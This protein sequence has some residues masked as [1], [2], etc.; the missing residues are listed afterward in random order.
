MRALLASAP[1]LIACGTYDGNRAA[2]VPHATPRMGDGQPP[3]ARGQLTLGASSVANLGEPRAGDPD[4][5]V[6]IA[7]T[8][9]FGSLRGRLGDSLSLGVIYE[10]GL[11]RGAEP[12]KS[13][14]PPVDGGSIHGYGLSADLSIRTGDPRIR[15]GLGAD[16]VL[17][18]VPYVEYVTCPPGEP[19]FPYSVGDRGRDA[20]ETFA[21]SLTPS[22]R[23]TDVITVF[24]G[25][26][27]RQ[28]PVIRQKGIE[29][30]PELSNPQVQSGPGNAILSG[31]MAL[32]LAGGALLASAIVYWDISSQPARY[33]PGLAMALSIPIGKHR[34]GPP[35]PQSQS[36]PGDVPPPP[37]PASLGPPSLEPEVP[38]EPAPPR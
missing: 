24:A 19:C 28:H 38:S 37:P 10:H 2:L 13:P 32:S 25:L 34:R 31:G 35:P 20:V 33:G 15:I 17:W 23:A 12:I 7:G 36:L 8:Q 14:Q 5:G 4:A 11:E 21:A 16:A 9:L 26:T 3:A 22:C 18:S 6:E 29:R 1:L 27:L 30:D